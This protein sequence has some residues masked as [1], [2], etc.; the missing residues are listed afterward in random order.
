MNHHINT[1][2]YIDHGYNTV[3]TQS[4]LNNNQLTQLQDQIHSLSILTLNVSGI[5]PPNKGTE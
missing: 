3:S 2:K 5:N 4:T 1:V